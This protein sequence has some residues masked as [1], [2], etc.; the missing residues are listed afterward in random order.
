MGMG[1]SGV[2]E[3]RGVGQK[4]QALHHGLKPRRSLHHLSIIRPIQAIRRRD[5]QGDPAEELF[6]CLGN[7]PRFIPG[8]VALFQH[9]NGI[10]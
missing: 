4:P 6:R 2:H 7:P 10:G 3:R 9:P 1:L 8:Q 5:G